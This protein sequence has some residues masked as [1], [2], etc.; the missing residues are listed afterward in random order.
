MNNIKNN[1]PSLEKIQEV[2]K[3]SYTDYKIIEEYINNNNLNNV[4]KR[5][6]YNNIFNNFINSNTD[7]SIQNNIICIKNVF[8]FSSKDLVNKLIDEI[9]KKLNIFDH[10]KSIY[11]SLKS[12]SIY[13]NKYV[14]NKTDDKTSH[15]KKIDCIID[16]LRNINKNNTKRIQLYLNKIIY[17]IDKY[18]KSNENLLLSGSTKI[19]R[20]EETYDLDYNKIINICDYIKD[21]QLNKNI[22][23]P[24]IFTL[25]NVINKCKQNI[26][27]YD[28][29]L[30]NIL[31]NVD[32]NIYSYIYFLN[33]KDNLLNEKEKN[34]S[35]ILN[36]DYKKKSYKDIDKLN[37]KRGFIQG[38]S[39]NNKDYLIKYQPNKSVMELIL[40]TELTSIDNKKYFLTPELIFINNDNSYFYII[41]KYNTDLYKYFNILEE[42]KQLLEFSD[43]LSIVSFL[44]NGIM[45]LH[46][47]NI[48]H[49]DFKLENIV[50]NIDKNNKIKDLRIID[51][52]VGVYNKIPKKLETVPERYSKILNNKKPRGTRIY[53]LKDKNITF[54]NDIYS[55]GVV[56][57]ILL[58]KS[59]K[60]IVSN[61]KKIFKNIEENCDNFKKMQKTKRENIKFQNILKNLNNLRETIE[62]NKNKIKMLNLIDSFLIKNKRILSF[63]NN[64]SEKL[65]SFKT[66]ILDCLNNKLYI[67]EINEK[68]YNLFN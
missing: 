12:L 30:E 67:N 55:L 15:I 25:L 40:N 31:K 68:Y 17:Y 62:D 43:I 63:F 61:K 3:L 58:Y 49:C 45:I 18:S 7:E 14:Q 44:I 4:S 34:L 39:K 32:K 33:N 24:L 27:V 50:M 19:I 37:L 29:D 21:Y 65:K 60:L 11:S 57:L 66:F 59:I 64:N 5:A 46:K 38:L 13:C 53:M 35:F 28:N 54:N 42:N 2:C 56:S 47:N 6:I 8:K 48:I 20:N 36:L 10:N 26:E 1:E 41:E 22:T 23:S 51:F 52:D 16:A 9:T